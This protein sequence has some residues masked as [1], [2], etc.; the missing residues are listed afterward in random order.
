MTK[1]RDPAGRRLFLEQASAALGAAVLGAGCGA[2]AEGAAGQG[3]ASTPSAGGSGG[4]PAGTGSTSTSAGGS[5]GDAG[6]RRSVV[7]A[8]SRGSVDEAVARAIELAGGLDAIS[9]G[10]TVFIKPNAVSDRAVGT[11]GIRTSLEVLGAV[12]RA[13]KTRDPGLVIVGDRSA[14]Q[15]PDTAAV[16]RNTGLADAALAAGADEVFTPLSPEDAPDQW[17]LVQPPGYESTWGADGGIHA[18]RRILEADHLINVPTCKDHRYA[19]FTLAMKNFIGAVGDRSRDPLHYAA[20]VAGNFGSIGR[21]IAIL[22]QIFHPL[23]TV[24]DAT[25]ALL[26]G[27]PQGDGADAVLTRPGL[28]F[29]SNDRVALDAL[30]V[31]LIQEEL[32]TAVVP[33]PDAAHPVLVRERAWSLPQIT[34]ASELG[35]GA[36]RAADVDLLWDG[37]ESGLA[38]AIEARFRA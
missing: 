21:D 22:N 9:P 5:R 10:Q 33:I 38:A 8:V 19:L 1:G 37:V 35:L 34:A 2:D 13:V 28:V 4:S 25:T 31:S 20:S 6:P 36:A 32:A 3:D 14:R 18:L 24:L 12:I 26:N 16:F 23:L 17:V 15:F 11:A 29:A 27:G 7:A 30:G